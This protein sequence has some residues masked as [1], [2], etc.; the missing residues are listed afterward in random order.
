M[1]WQVETWYTLYLA[2]FNW[3]KK[4]KKKI[5]ADGDADRRWLG[6][7]GRGACGG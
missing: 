2:A 6:H 1:D 3:V 4:K 5:I 7:V